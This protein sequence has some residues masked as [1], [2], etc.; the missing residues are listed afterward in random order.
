[1]LKKDLMPKE[2]SS[3]VLPTLVSIDTSGSMEGIPLEEVKKGLLSFRDAIMEDTKA[4]QTV[5]I[6]CVT[7]NNSVQPI[8]DDFEPVESLTDQVV[9]N[10]QANGWTHLYETHEVAFRLLENYKKNLSM[11]GIN[12]YRPILI[13]LTDGFPT[14]VPSNNRS[15]WEDIRRYLHGWEE[16][17]RFIPYVFATTSA[18]LEFLRWLYPEGRAF[19]VPNADFSKVFQWLSASV[20][21]QS[22]G[23]GETEENQP[24][25]YGLD[26]IPL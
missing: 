7:F 12:Y 24:T 14:D 6:Q 9:N 16:H 10:L 15:E 17:K 2:V 20:S 11:Q 4:K 3:K 1:M 5:R 18:D 22:H 19:L 21:A 25:A 26:Y 13:T 23:I 8:F